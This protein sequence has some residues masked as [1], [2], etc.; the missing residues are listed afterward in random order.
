M[1]NIFWSLLATALFFLEGCA[2]NGMANTHQPCSEKLY[3]TTWNLRM[4]DNDRIDLKHP[5][6]I[7]FDDDG[8]ISG[9]SGCNHYFAKAEL[10]ATTITFGPVGSTRRYCMGEAGKVEQRLFSLFKGKKWWNF[11]EKKRLQIFDDE[12]RLVFERAE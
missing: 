4:I 5:A 3:G 10:T 7:H 1:G 12:H 8:K 9:Y 2:V 6:T 11:D